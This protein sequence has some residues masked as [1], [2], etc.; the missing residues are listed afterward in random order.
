MAAVVVTDSGGPGEYVE[1]GVTGFVIPVGDAPA[2]AARLETLLANPSL[3]GRLAEAARHRVEHRHD[4]PRMMAAVRGVYDGV[5]TADR[6][7]SS[8]V[9]PL[10]THN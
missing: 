2:L 10:V 9:V 8:P 6:P 5:R 7:S 1:D 4:Y 3:A